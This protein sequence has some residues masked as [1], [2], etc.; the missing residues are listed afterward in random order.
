MTARFAYEAL[1]ASDRQHDA[2]ART[3][4]ATSPVLAP[5]GMANGNESGSAMTFGPRTSKV[6]WTKKKDGFAG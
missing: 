1:F 4:A 3:Y 2:L 6:K 5:E